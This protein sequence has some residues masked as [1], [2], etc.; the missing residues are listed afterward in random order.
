MRPCNALYCTMYAVPKVINI[1]R[2]NMKCCG[3]IMILRG[4]FCVESF[5]PLH[6]VL[7]HGNFD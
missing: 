6:F 5:F 4:I 2:Y 3:E 7:Y 1:P